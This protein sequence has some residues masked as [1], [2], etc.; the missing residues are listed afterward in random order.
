MQLLFLNSI[1]HM[2]IVENLRKV[3]ITV[4]KHLKPD[5]VLLIV[6]NI[7]KE[8]EEN[9][10]VYTGSKGDVEITVFET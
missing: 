5:E 3:I 4:Y 9:N 1:G 7:R 6:A 2:T 8:F 10:F